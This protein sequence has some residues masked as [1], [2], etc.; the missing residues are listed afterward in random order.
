MM[1]F[2]NLLIVLTALC[3]IFISISPNRVNAKQLINDL[4]NHWAKAAIEK[5]LK[6]GYI[7]GYDD[8]TFRP[9]RA[10]TRA[11]F[12]KVIV[13]AKQITVSDKDTPFTDDKGWYRPFIATG[14]THSLIK[15]TDYSD[16]KFLPNQSI[17][18]GEVAKIAV[19]SLGKDKE[20]LSKGYIYTSKQLGILQGDSNGNVGMNKLATRAEAVVIIQRILNLAN[21]S[22]AE[23]EP[24]KVPSTSGQIATMVKS[25][26]TYQ[27]K[28]MI[29][30]NTVL[31]NPEGTQDATDFTITIEYVKESKATLITVYEK[32]SA[33]KSFFLEVLKQY[34][35]KSSDQ[36]Y[37]GISKVYNSKVVNSSISTTY[38]QRKVQISKI[39][40]GKTI[41]IKIN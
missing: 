20:G 1:R 29:S 21:K 33:H 34:F 5:A 9:D 13:S 25:L 15:M 24:L 36:A 6:S 40:S 37:Q 23:S 31:V 26:D 27:G 38:D 7:K 3:L 30:G 18:R 19:R 10:M 39:D 4:N 35:P 28:T 17:T 16:K 22:V 11:E 2:R 8:G 12:L 32:P 14:L 41:S